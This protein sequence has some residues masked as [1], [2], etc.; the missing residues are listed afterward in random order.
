[1]YLVF[2]Y[3]NFHV[4]VF[5]HL[6]PDIQLFLHNPFSSG[7]H[8]KIV[9]R[10][11]YCYFYWNHLSMTILWIYYSFLTFLFVCFSISSII[12]VNSVGF[13]MP[14]SCRPFSVLN[15][16][17]SMLFVHT[18]FLFTLY[19]YKLLFALR[20][21]TDMVILFNNCH[22]FLFGRLF[23]ITLFLYSTT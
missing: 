14:P 8:C 4:P 22:I 13:R 6:L 1:M 20:M 2:C 9:C 16:W 18:Y 5:E 12:I 3:I 15:S 11:T 7:P 17:D 23:K 19:K 21:R 10:P